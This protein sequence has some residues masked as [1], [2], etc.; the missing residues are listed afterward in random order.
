MKKKIMGIVIAIVMLFAVAGLSACNTNTLTLR[1]EVDA[2]GVRVYYLQNGGTATMADL[3]ALLE[4]IDALKDRVNELEAG[5]AE[6]LA[7]L[8]VLRQEVERMAD[9][10]EAERLSADFVLNIALSATTLQFGQNL[11]LEA[12]FKNN[13]SEQVELSHSGGWIMPSIAYWYPLDNILLTILE[14]NEIITIE[15]QLGSR[16]QRGRHKLIAEATFRTIQRTN[17]NITSSSTFTVKS[18]K[19]VLTVV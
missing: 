5:N 13:T 1:D 16:L 8:V 11:T 10:K 9:T 6:L 18:N 17:G 19:I 12:V 4:Q 7:E 14:P 2:I 15:W 3:D